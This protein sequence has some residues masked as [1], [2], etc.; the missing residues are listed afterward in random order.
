[1]LDFESPLSDYNAKPEIGGS[2]GKNTHGGSI[3]RPDGM[4]TK[5][6][7]D[8]VVSTKKELLDAITQDGVTVW[9]DRS[10]DEIDITG[11]KNVWIG[12][13]ITLVGGF[14]DPKVDGRGPVLKNDY[15]HRHIFRTR[16][17]VTFYGV[18]FRGP[19]TEYF[20]PRERVQSSDWNSDN[21]D[22]WFSSG[23]HAH[24]SKGNGTCKFVGCEFWGWTLAGIEIGAKNYMTQAVVER[25]SFHDSPMETAGY[26][27]EHYNGSVDVRHCFFDSSRHGI[28]GFGHRNEEIH[29]KDSVFGP[30]PWSG[31]A[32][33]MHDLGANIDGAGNVAGRYLRADR[34]TF[35]GT[36]DVRGY[37]QEG[38]AIRGVPVE[39]SRVSD[40]HFYHSSKP[41]PTGEEGDAY[42]QAVE[43]GWKRFTPENNHFGKEPKDGHGAPRVQEKPAEDDEDKETENP[44]GTPTAPDDSTMKLT[45]HGRGTSGEYEIVVHGTVK[46]TG[47][48][49]DNDSIE[50]LGNNRR[51][52][53]GGIV[54]AADTFELG[55][56]ATI[57]RAWFTAPAR[58]TKNGEPIDTGSLVAAEADRRLTEQSKR[59]D[60]L[61]NWVT[62][63]LD[64]L[65]IVIG[66]GTNE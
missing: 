56:N 12:E 24:P 49:E 46:P 3:D 62:G 26:G 39:E 11:A 57:E 42:R 37:D 66:G 60:Q 18:A 48:I 50:N 27:I 10:V 31:H 65:N 28:S 15:Y 23:I 16:S 9:L 13:D 34:C 41:D 53:S 21:L 47:N 14:C 35:M 43:D 59:I 52:V 55:E 63:R 22:D 58:I 54:G 25:C 20:D 7:A 29:V 1:M 6:D 4:P 44:S 38:L 5:S 61:R 40:S 19:N 33:D 32:L 51:K 17:P 36:R 64:S 2:A 45:I 30:G 8:H